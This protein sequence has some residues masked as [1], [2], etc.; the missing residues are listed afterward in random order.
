MTEGLAS[1]S[2]FKNMSSATLFHT[3][4]AYFT[5]YTVAH[6]LYAC[7]QVNMHIYVFSSPN[8]S[9][10]IKCTTDQHSSRS[11]GAV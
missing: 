7:T 11:D 6:I 8:V 1:P 5:Q 4:V 9:G 3:Y 2:I 10:R